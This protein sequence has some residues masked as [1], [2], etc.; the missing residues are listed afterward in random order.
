LFNVRDVR[1]I[2]FPL[3]W[4]AVTCPMVRAM[5]R[6]FDRRVAELQVRI[7]VLNGYTPTGIPVT[8]AVG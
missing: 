1:A 4:V 2:I 7:S 5:A 3:A 8:D 6:N